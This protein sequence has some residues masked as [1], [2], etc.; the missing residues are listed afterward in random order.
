MEPTS[1]LN[2]PH[3][4]YDDNGNPIPSNTIISMADHNLSHIAGVTPAGHTKRRTPLPTP[5]RLSTQNGELFRFAT[6]AMERIAALQSTVVL[7]QKEIDSLIPTTYIRRISRVFSRL[8]SRILRRYF[9]YFG[10]LTNAGYI[11]FFNKSF[12]AGRSA[13]EVGGDTAIQSDFYSFTIS[14]LTRSFFNTHHIYQQQCP[15]NRTV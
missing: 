1:L 10:R 3:T 12:E 7:Q 11:R 4:T 14:K 13:F 2:G 9:N 8:V 6:S 5:N 15:G